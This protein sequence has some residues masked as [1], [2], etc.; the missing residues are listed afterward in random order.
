MDFTI[1]C[2]C[3]QQ[4]RV[5]TADAGGSKRCHCGAINAVPSLSELRR[6]AG[7][8]SYDV[9]IADKLRYMFADGELPPDNA[10]VLCGAETP[11]ILQCSVE[12]ERPHTKGRGFWGT[13]L[14][15]I[16]AP[17][18]V[19]V[20]LICEYKDAEVFGREL[21][22]TTPLPLCPECAANAQPRKHNVRELL[23]RVP[24]YDQLFQEYPNADADVLPQLTQITIG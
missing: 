19:L 3:G 22:V 16:F 18:W 20:L 8:Q 24:L 11:N 7:K 15:G 23:R 14:L 12:C 10:C 4:L 13:V 21:I 1:D 9:A 6:L 2:T 17:V 5:G